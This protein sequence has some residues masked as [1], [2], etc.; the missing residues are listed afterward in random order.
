M[1]SGFLRLKLLLRLLKKLKY[2]LRSCCGR[3]QKVC[4]LRDLL[5]WLCKVT[6]VLEK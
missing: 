3:L 2:P 5:D 1:E 4:Y 6:D